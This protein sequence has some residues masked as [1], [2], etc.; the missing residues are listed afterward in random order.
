[1]TVLSA[2]PGIPR[3]AVNTGV[4]LWS[5]SIAVAGRMVRKFARTPRAT[6]HTST[7]WSP[8]SS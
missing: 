5:S 1:M 4:G 2:S 3:A 8:A 7:S 6:C